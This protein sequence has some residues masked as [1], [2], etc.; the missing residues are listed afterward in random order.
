MNKSL[1]VK[2][3]SRQREY[4]NSG[5]S[6]NLQFRL[7]MLSRLKEVLFKNE[8]P[9]LWLAQSPPVTARFLNLQSWPGLHLP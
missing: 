2:L 5:E 6:R 7:A 9:I 1:I 8:Q 4:F 3:V